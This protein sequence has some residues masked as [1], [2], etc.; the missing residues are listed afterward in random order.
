MSSIHQ[1]SDHSLAAKL[2]GFGPI[3]IFAILVII[4]SGNIVLPGM[5]L[6]PVGAIFALLWTRFSHT[7][8]RQIGYIRPKSWSLTAVI[9]LMVGTVLKFFMKAII[10]P[11]LG[12]PINHTYHF[13]AGN[14]AI[15]P[16]AVLAMLVTGF[17][18]ETVFRGYLFERFG[19]LFGTGLRA[20]LLILFLTST[21]FAL[22]HLYDQG[23]NGMVQA[24]ITGLV[25]GSIYSI[26]RNLWLA[27]IAHAA[28]DLTVLTIIYLNLESKV[29]HLLFD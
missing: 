19:K 22:G 1:T 20:T 13:L 4:F 6:L 12:D 16:T 14:T 15:L 10:L 23:T 21:L 3:G 7:P 2:R 27:M 18:E 28:F 9:G 25:F 11:L 26:T 17:A 5:I 8:W 24:A 29:A